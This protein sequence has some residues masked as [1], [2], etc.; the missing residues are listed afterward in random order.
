VRRQ[1]R[2]KKALGRW[3]VGGFWGFKMRSKH[4]GNMKEENYSSEKLVRGG[5]MKRCWYRTYIVEQ[6]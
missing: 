5:E 3:A 6:T 2:R 1:R 4:G